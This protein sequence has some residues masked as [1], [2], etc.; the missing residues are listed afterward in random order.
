[1]PQKQ[2]NPIRTRLAVEDRLKFEQI[3]RAEN[4]SETDLARRALLEFI[5]K[6]D[7]GVEAG[8]RDRLAEVLLAM[9]DSHKKDTER[10]AKMLARVMMDV[11]IV[12][13]VF[14]KRA[15][16]EDRDALWSEAQQAAAQRLRHKRKGGDPEA[17]EISTDALS[18]EA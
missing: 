5:D 8:A 14:Y 6:Y 12:N 2:T 9:N 17:A 3:C 10:L 1:M 4:V 7:Q 11:G 13:Q 18:R 16:K 15:S